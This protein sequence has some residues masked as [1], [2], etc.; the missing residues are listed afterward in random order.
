M[1]GLL[2]S[3]RL[4]LERKLSERRSIRSFVRRQGRITAG[5][6]RAIRENWSDYVLNLAD[7]W[8]AIEETLN[9]SC[10]IILEIGFGMGVSLHNQA[11]SDP[12]SNYIGIEVYLPGLGNLIGLLQKSQLKNVRLF[13]EDAV[14]VLR[15]VIKDKS[16]YKVQLFFPDPWP[17][18]KHLKRRL[19]NENF[20][21]LIS[22]KLKRNGEFVLVTDSHSYYCYA[23][24]L[25]S[26]RSDFNRMDSQEREV[27]KYEKRALTLGNEVHD[28][29]YKLCQ[30]N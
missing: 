1:V 19:I 27:T 29:T 3:R 22:K 23:L 8:S 26:S 28:V 4:L 20:I 6:K 14:E 30:Q 7:G 18:K 13:C 5:Q 25:F 24:D 10:P 15:H 11:Q 2:F 16:L 17:K 9:L 12:H 21:D